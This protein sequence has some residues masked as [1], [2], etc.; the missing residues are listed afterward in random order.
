MDAT[1]RPDNGVTKSPSSPDVMSKSTNISQSKTKSTDSGP[2]RATGAQTFQGRPSYATIAKKALSNER[3]D[4]V[5]KAS[6][7][8]ASSQPL[9]TKGA[10]P[11]D[12]R[13]TAV[14][15]AVSRD[16]QATAQ[17]RDISGFGLG[18]DAQSRA[19]QVSPTCCRGTFTCGHHY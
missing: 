19:G 6:P 7:G 8:A 5:A 10:R 2:R 9:R 1:S 16:R 18:L 4:G 12:D 14:P 17:H 11:A 15:A 13:S 3:L